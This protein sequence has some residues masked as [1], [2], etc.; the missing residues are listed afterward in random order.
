[1]PDFKH[2]D[3]DCEEEECIA[4]KACKRQKHPFKVKFADDCDPI[5]VKFEDCE[6][7]KVKIEEECHPLHVKQV[8]GDCWRVSGCAEGLPVNVDQAND[9][10]WAVEGCEGGVPIHVIV[11]NTPP[12]PTVSDHQFVYDGTNW[13]EE[14]TPSKF[15]VATNL[16]ETIPAAVWTPAP[17]ARFRLMGFSL[18][19]SLAGQFNLRDGFGGPILVSL[20]FQAGVPYPTI[21]LGNGIA[22]SGVNTPLVLEG[23]GPVAA[24]S[25]LF[26]GQETL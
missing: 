16:Q 19:S 23:P 24:I 2:R 14:R 10:C 20:I 15:V 17:G 9:T 7:I 13:V 8:K 6:P 1:M 3:D 22:S 5:P 11:D 21:D 12:P 4:V 26:W 25:G 18:T